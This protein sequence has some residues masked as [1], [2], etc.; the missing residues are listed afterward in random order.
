MKNDLHI[1]N[2]KQKKITEYNIKSKQKTQQKTNT[3]QKKRHN[4]TRNY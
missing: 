4:K 3:T 2:N 1:F